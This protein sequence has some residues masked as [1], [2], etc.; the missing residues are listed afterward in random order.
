MGRMAQK[1]MQLQY[2]IQDGEVLLSNG[3]ESINIE[4]ETL[5]PG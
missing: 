5:L 4:P 2:T 3:K 1:G